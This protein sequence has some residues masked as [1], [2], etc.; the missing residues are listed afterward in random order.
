L[1]NNLVKQLK[2]LGVEGIDGVSTFEELEKAVTKL[3]SKAL[4]KVDDALTTA[5]QELLKM[6]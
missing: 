3:N 5:K 6:G 4:A 2:E 1:F